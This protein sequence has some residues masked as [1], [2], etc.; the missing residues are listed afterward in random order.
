MAGEG[1]Y[2]P[3][4]KGHPVGR[5]GEMSE[6]GEGLLVEVALG[7]PDRIE[8]GLLGRPRVPGQLGPGV[9]PVI[10]DQACQHVS[11]S[12]TGGIGAS[13]SSS[14]RVAPRTRI[15]WARSPGAPSMLPVFSRVKVARGGAVRLVMPATALVKV[16]AMPSCS[17]SLAISPTD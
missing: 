3:H 9:D 14:E 6:Q 10:E 2:H 16:V 13:R 5:C 8:A 11:A 1:V 15:C 7:D 17:R 4:A 12:L